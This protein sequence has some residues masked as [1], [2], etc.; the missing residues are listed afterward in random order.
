MASHTMQTFSNW[1]KAIGVKKI[2]KLSSSLPTVIFFFRW[3]KKF[4]V[5]M[6]SVVK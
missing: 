6:K 5:K 4:D 3:I 2:I 1:C